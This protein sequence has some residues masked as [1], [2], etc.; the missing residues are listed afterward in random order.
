MKEK[1]KFSRALKIEFNYKTNKLKRANSL[2][3][4][5]II[6]INKFRIPMDNINSEMRD[7][8][9][10]LNTE[11]VKKKIKNK[12]LIKKTNINIA[13]ENIIVSLRRELKFQKL[14]NKNLLSFKEYA[15]KN[16]NEYKTNYDNICRYRN[17][18]HE[19][20]SGFVAVVN[21]FENDI[22]NFK[23]EKEMMIKTNE[24]LINYKSEEQNNK[25]AR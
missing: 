10:V 18:I 11:N 15:D 6:H 3:P 21:K 13:K 14:L 19:D 16:S 12:L 22:N 1:G 23:R 4:N 2:R 17:Q 9:K 8:K 5:K 20:L 24:S 7:I 25:N